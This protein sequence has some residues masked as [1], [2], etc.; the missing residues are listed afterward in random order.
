MV[1]RDPAGLALGG[2]LVAWQT[3]AV[4]RQVEASRRGLLTPMLRG[5]SLQSSLKLWQVRKTR[6]SEAMQ[7]DSKHIRVHD[8]SYGCTLAAAY[9]Q[10][11]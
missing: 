2:I 1:H 11:A 5:V 8:T 9:I 4:S 7:H 6:A 3:Q 10:R